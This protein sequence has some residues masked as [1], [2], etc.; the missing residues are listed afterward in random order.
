[1]GYRV[2]LFGIRGT[3]LFNEM[4]Q[5]G[6][7]CIAY[8]TLASREIRIN[9]EEDVKVY[10]GKEDEIKIFQKNIGQT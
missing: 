9:R 1:M 6:I 7:E 8:R 3:K 2:V 4:E 5:A 10:L